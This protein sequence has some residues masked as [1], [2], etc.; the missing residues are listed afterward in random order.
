MFPAHIVYINL[1][2]RTDRRAQIEA[3]LDRVLGTPRSTTIHRFPAIRHLHGAV[4]CALSHLA[5]LRMAQSAQW[6]EVLI[7][8]DDVWFTNPDLFLQQYRAFREKQHPFDVL[9]LSGNV[10]PPVQSVDDTCVRVRHCQTTAAYLVQRHYY[11]VLMRNIHEGVTRLLRQPHN[12]RSFA[13]DRYWFS[14]QARDQWLL[15]TPLTVTQ[16][17]G[18]SDIEGSHT[19]YEQCILDLEKPWLLQRP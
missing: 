2:H 7:L 16:R 1:D 15:L 6:D 3:E 9:L 17:A 10:I 5:V 8:E 12:K 4:G 18:Y 14:L 13:I 19:D 11:E